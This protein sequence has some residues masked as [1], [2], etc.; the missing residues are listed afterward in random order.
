MDD[1]DDGDDDGD[2]DDAP[3]PPGQAGSVTVMHKEFH[4]TPPVAVHSNAQMNTS[5]QDGRAS[6]P[7]LC[8]FGV[9]ALV[10]LALH[11]KAVLC[12]VMIA[13]MILGRLL[14]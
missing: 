10:D 4:A 6:L 9:G 7:T 12:L 5:S 8:A 14:R 2:D 13:C 11:S 3:D 1:D